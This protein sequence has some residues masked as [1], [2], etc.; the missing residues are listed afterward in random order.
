MGVQ[1]FF[2]KKRISQNLIQCKHI[3]RP[4]QM[5]KTQNNIDPWKEDDLSVPIRSKIRVKRGKSNVLSIFDQCRKVTQAG[6]SRS[7]LKYIY[8]KTLNM[9]QR[10]WPNQPACKLA[11]DPSSSL[12]SSERTRQT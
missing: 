6:R 4:A 5:G 1:G 9:F 3:E 12:P 11:G 8:D 7:S 10:P 2:G